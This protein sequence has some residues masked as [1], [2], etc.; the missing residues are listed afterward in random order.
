MGR[1][2]GRDHSALIQNGYLTTAIFMKPFRHTSII[3]LVVWCQL[4]WAQEAQDY[5]PDELYFQT[6]TTKDGLPSQNTYNTYQD[7]TGFLWI[8]TDEGLTRYD[9]YEFKPYFDDIKAGIHLKGACGF[10]EDEAGTLWVISGLG[11]LHRYDRSRDVFQPVRLPTQDGWS[12]PAAHSII[13]DEHGHLWISG[14]GGIQY[15]RP[16]QD[17]V[18]LIKIE[19]VRSPDTWPHPEKVRIGPMHLQAG[20]A[21]WMG[22]IKFGFIKYDLQSKAFTYYRFDPRFSLQYLDDWIA[23]IIPLDE[24]TLL[25]ADKP[26]GLVFWDME[27]E[28]IKRIIDVTPLINAPQHVVINDV[29]PLT[30]DLY[31]LATNQ[32]GIILID[33]RNESILRHYQ[34]NKQSELGIDGIQINHLSQDRN[35]AYWIGSSSLQLCSPKLK[36]F[37]TYYAESDQYDPLV[38]NDISGIEP[39]ADGRLLLSTPVGVCGYDPTDHKFAFPLYGIPAGTPSYGLLSSRTG[40]T[41][42]GTRFHLYQHEQEAGQITKTFASNLIVDDQNNWLRTI[43]KIIEDDRGHL[44]MIDH[45]GRLKYHNPETDEVSNVYELVQDSITGKFINVLDIIDDPEHQRIIVGMDIGL[46]LVSYDKTVSRP[47]LS[48]DGLNLSRSM[49]SYFYRDDADR[50]WGIV[51]GQVYRYHSEDGSLDLLDLNVRYQVGA[52]RWMIEEP[53][54]VY[55]LASHRGIIRYDQAAGRSSLHYTENVGGGTLDA[56]S[57]VA[58]LDGLIYFSGYKGLSVIDPQKMS[59][60]QKANQVVIT[61]IYVNGEKH[62]PADLTADVVRIELDHDQNDL[63]IA[64]SNFSFV[65]QQECQYQYRLLPQDKDW[66]KHGSD[67]TLALYNLAPDD[68][69]LEID[70]SSSDGQWT[71]QPLRMEIYISPAWWDTIFAKGLFF[72]LLIGAI[73]YYQRMRYLQRLSKQ[74]EMEVL[75]NKISKDLHDDVGTVLTGIA[76]QSELLENFVGK[77]SKPMAEQIAAKSRQAMERMRDTVW[78]I[79]SRRDS[80]LDLKDRMLDFIEDNLPS[81]EITY[82]LQTHLFSESQKLAPNARQAAYLIFKESII[83]I[84]KHSDTSTI[85]IN[86]TTSKDQLRIDI[87]DHGTQQTRLRTSGQGLRNMES[88]AEE[89]GGQ[90]SFEY[91]DGYRTSVILPIA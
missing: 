28:K 86:I 39:T 71:D 13:P 25:L 34:P 36:E 26:N 31:W 47:V 58:E 89:I 15:Y 17:S 37:R 81:T 61:D 8:S 16:A 44:W 9:G 54:G 10:Y 18:E 30:K 75:R 33:I 91:Q 83:N 56:P 66:V 3:F 14:H 70:A 74:R 59:V 50:L 6:F 32:S 88:R 45:W 90:Y 38:H 7:K 68:Y 52:F 64:L 20:K 55:W 57:P 4:A 80:I 48:H 23:D 42:I 79:D 41:W 49:Y 53:S 82:H 2:W 87:Q 78:A 12:M 85:E 43:R 46:A 19:A 40:H 51:N 76:M 69:T 84:M 27:Q 60:S 65:S 1:E 24:E 11:Y 22:T 73:V 5:V 77:D 29:H 35:G 67:H 72:L 63:D 21:L 62:V